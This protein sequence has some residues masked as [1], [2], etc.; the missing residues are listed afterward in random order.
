MSFWVAVLDP[1]PMYRRGVIQALGG[2]GAELQSAQEL[3]TWLRQEPRRVVVLTLQR[4]DDWALLS[5]LRDL[6]PE[7][8]VVAVLGQ[9]STS[10]YVRAVLAG[11]TAVLPR[12]AP[13]DLVEGVLREI[14]AGRSVLPAQ[15]V[16]ALASQEEQPDE[17]Q[18]TLSER[19][20]EWLR[21]LAGGSTVVELADRAGYSERAMFRLLRDVYTRMGVRN[22]TEALMRAQERG[23]L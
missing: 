16:R 14:S 2:S 12:D 7:A 17:D 23:W 22:K 10:A 5:E 13:A 8:L 20:L 3:R 6:T 21:A 19:E 18:D 9:V 1:L 15:V 11:A 4:P